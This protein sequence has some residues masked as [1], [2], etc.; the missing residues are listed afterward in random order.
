MLLQRL[1]LI[2]LKQAL[3]FLAHTFRQIRQNKD[4]EV[5]LTYFFLLFFSY[6]LQRSFPQKIVRLASLQY[7]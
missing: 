3:K 2:V 6:L 4:L 7:G 1:V 5:C